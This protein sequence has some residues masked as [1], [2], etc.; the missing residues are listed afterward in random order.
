MSNTKT[1]AAP[2]TPKPNPEISAAIDKTIEATKALKTEPAQQTKPKVAPI[3]ERLERF[4]MIEKHVIQ[5]EL[6]NESLE[7]LKEFKASP[8]GGDQII[9]RQANGKTINTNH[10]EAI[11]GMIQSAIERLNAKKEEL[12][13]FIVL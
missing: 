12:E 1:V 6:V 4:Q 10:P 11:E 8:N 5:L 9:I 7:D 3:S 13:S 2:A